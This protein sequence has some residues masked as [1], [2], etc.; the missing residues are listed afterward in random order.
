MW[1]AFDLGIRPGGGGDTNPT[2][3]LLNPPTSFEKRQP[4]VKQQWEKTNT[5]KL[6]VCV[7]VVCVF[8]WLYGHC[9]QCRGYKQTESVRK[10]DDFF[11]SF[12]GPSPSKPP[13]TNKKIKF[14]KNQSANT[15]G[16][17]NTQ[18][19]Q[20]W[21][22]FILTQK[23]KKRKP[24]VTTW[25]LKKTKNKQKQNTFTFLFFVFCEILTM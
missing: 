25:N 18:A 1:G 6:S 24:A 8:L 16:Q 17:R 4:T 7:S 13:Q 12:L 11:F 20:N 15:D 22:S 21:Q 3:P 23:W 2:P 10:V 19:Q 9:V 5:H 14:K